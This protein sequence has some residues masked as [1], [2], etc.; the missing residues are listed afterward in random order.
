M[1]LK[2]KWLVEF[3]NEVSEKLACPGNPGEGLS[4]GYPRA[5]K[6]LF[7]YF[8]LFCQVVNLDLFCACGLEGGR[9]GVGWIENGKSLIRSKFKEFL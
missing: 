7:L 1:I 2:C 8:Y 6:L 3:F 4:N 5:L 9:V